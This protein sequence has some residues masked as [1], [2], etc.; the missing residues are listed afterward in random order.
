MAIDDN[1]CI[2]VFPAIELRIAK[3]IEAQQRRRR[4]WLRAFGVARDDNSTRRLLWQLEVLIYVGDDAATDSIRCATSN[5]LHRRNSFKFACQ[6]NWK[7]IFYSN[8]LE[9]GPPRFMHSHE[10]TKTAPR[11]SEN[12]QRKRN[13]WTKNFS[14]VHQLA[15]SLIRFRFIFDQQLQSWRRPTWKK[16]NW[17]IYPTAATNL[18]AF[19]SLLIESKLEKVR[20]PLAGFQSSE[21]LEKCLI[22]VFVCTAIDSNSLRWLRPLNKGEL[23]LLSAATRHQQRDRNRYRTFGASLEQQ[24]WFGNKH[25]FNGFDPHQEATNS[26]RGERIE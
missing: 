15:L 4:Q 16:L 1:L 18:V 21:R 13:D 3:L 12:E 24:N 20:R 10:A 17:I 9:N 5:R 26:S 23:E 11:G 25:G 8:S 19:A 2:Y 22:E 14:R 7:L 6:C